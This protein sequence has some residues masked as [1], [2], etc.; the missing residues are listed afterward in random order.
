MTNEEVRQ[1]YLDEFGK[2]PAL[3]EAWVRDGIELEER[4]RRAWQ[5]RH[6]ARIT[7]RSMME[8]PL[9]VEKLRERDVKFYR[10]PDGPSFEYQV[11]EAKAKG[12]VGEKIYE[13][14]IASSQVSNTEINRKLNIRRE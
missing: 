10:N 4:A 2:I 8:N 1:W 3:N 12:L 11:E 9:E 5:I 6:N 7:A 14:I 13:S